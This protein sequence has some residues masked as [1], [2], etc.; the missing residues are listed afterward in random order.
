MTKELI[1]TLLPLPIRKELC[2]FMNRRAWIDADARYWWT[3]EL[4]RDFEERDRNA[5]HRFLWSHH[6]AYAI[7]YEAEC[8]FGKE[9]IK[10]SRMMF[11][12]DLRNHLVDRGIAPRNDIHSVFEV[13]CSL[14]YQLRY[15]ETD[16]F[17]GARELAGVDIDD[18]AILQGAEY[19]QRQGSKILLKCGDMGNLDNLL[20][21]KMYDIILCTGVLM[22]LDEEQ[23]ARAV[24]EMLQHC[25]VMVALSGPAHPDTDNSHLAHSFIRKLDGSFIHNFDA[26]VKQADG[27]IVARRWEGSRVIDGHTIYFVFAAGTS[28]S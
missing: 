17:P 16:V 8:R 5:Y 3:K 26:M 4:L 25:R 7:S 28:R 2:I 15:L 14:G 1:R 20:G 24:E 13:G 10:G 12:S 22:Y 18:H 21:D 23:A 27:N 6:L 11:F 19:L 9:N